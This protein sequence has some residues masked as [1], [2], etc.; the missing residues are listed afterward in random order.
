MCGDGKESM[1]NAEIVSID[2]Q[3]KKYTDEWSK[4]AEEVDKQVGVAVELS[5]KIGE[6][7]EK[8]MRI[9]KECG[10]ENGAMR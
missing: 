5:N 2:A 8:R 6:L 9:E 10:C 4:A 1:R 7:Q 3:I